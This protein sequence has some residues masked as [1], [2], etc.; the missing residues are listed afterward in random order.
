MHAATLCNMD[1]DDVLRRQG[2]VLARHQAIAAGLGEPAISR[3]LA[4]GRWARL[5]PGVYLVD[6][7]VTDLGRLHAAALWAG[8]EAPSL[9]WPRPGGTSWFRRRRP[10]CR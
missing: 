10:S 5:H 1:L 9:V 4:C 3:R 8:C 6:R 7:E 2:G